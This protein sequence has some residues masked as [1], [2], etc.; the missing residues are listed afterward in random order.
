[1][2]SKYP[3]PP[4]PQDSKQAV[5]L[6]PIGIS[7]EMPANPKMVAEI[8]EI[9]IG[10]KN[11]IQYKCVWWDGRSRKNEWFEEFEIRPTD[12]QLS[13]NSF[14]FHAIKDG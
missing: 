6:I 11:H 4:P 8:I 13:H 1:M 5:K 7:V 12:N 9:S 2:A 3:T 14:G 10:P